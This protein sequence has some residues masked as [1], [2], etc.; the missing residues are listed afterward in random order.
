MAESMLAPE[1]SCAWGSNWS[2]FC[3]IQGA[4]EVLSNVLWWLAF[5]GEGLH[6]TPVC[7]VSAGFLGAWCWTSSGRPLVLEW[8]PGCPQ[9][10]VLGLF[11]CSVLCLQPIACHHLWGIA[12]RNH[13][14][15]IV[16]TLP[17][18]MVPNESKNIMKAAKSTGREN[19]L[20]MDWR[21][22]FLPAD[23]H[24][25]LTSRQW[26]TPLSFRTDPFLPAYQF[27]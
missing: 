21:D 12:W 22:W 4:L 16:R 18:L 19:S 2:Q 3:S 23:S 10:T 1:I 27:R 6:W 15:R 11:F 8:L 26:A 25:L 14:G 5:V 7:R 17:L 24:S 13:R 20:G 9:L